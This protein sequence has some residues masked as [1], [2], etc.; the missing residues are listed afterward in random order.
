LSQKPRIPPE[1]AKEIQE[2]ARQRGL[3]VRQIKN[4]GPS[5]IDDLSKA[6]GM[7]KDKVFRHL[8]AMLRFGKIMIVGERD[9]D[10]L[11]GLPEGEEPKL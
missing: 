3:I 1:K 6:T 2:R 4:Q 9:N 5:T 11:Y 10:L 7:E 8:I